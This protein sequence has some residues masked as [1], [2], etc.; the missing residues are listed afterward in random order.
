MKLLKTEEDA[1]VKHVLDLNERGFLLQLAVVKDTVDNLL[2][3]CHRDPVGQ[4]RAVTFV[5]RRPKLKVKFI[6]K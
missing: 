1:I 6:H 2:A 5:K 4:N 3:E